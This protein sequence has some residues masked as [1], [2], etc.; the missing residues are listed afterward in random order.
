MPISVTMPTVGIL[1]QPLDPRNVLLV[2]ICSLY[3]FLPLLLHCQTSRTQHLNLTRVTV[4]LNVC[5][6][7]TQNEN[8]QLTRH[9]NSLNHITQKTHHS[10]RIKLTLYRSTTSNIMNGHGPLLLPYCHGIQP[11]NLHQTQ[12]QRPTL[13][14][15][16]PISPTSGTTLHPDTTINPTPALPLYLTLAVSSNP[17][18]LPKYPNLSLNKVTT[19]M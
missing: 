12:L 10:H 2:L 19:V 17:F 13:S 18:Q 6:S 8:T 1:Y 9:S 11:S 16:I 4:I 7:F 14:P 15:S 5:W 3:P